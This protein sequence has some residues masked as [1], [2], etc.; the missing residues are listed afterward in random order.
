MT[1]T[2]AISKRILMEMM[3]DKRTLALMFLA[4]VLILTLLNYVFT[5]NSTPTVEIG[6]VRVEQVVTDSLKNT[7]HVNT[8]SYDSESKAKSALKDKD[9]DAV[10]TQTGTN[11]YQLRYANI[12]ASKTSMVRQVVNSTF[13]QNKVKA[14][15]Q[16]NVVLATQAGQQPAAT[17]SVSLSEKYNYGS[18]NTTFFDTIMPIFMGFFVFMFVFLISGISLLKERTTGTLSRLLATPVRR[19]EIVYGYMLSYAL[20][21]ILQTAVIVSFTITLLH[22]EVL[23]SVG[24]LFL[25]NIL[26]AMVALALGLLVS[27]LAASEFQMIQ[28]IPIV[29]V[30]QMIFSGIIPFN[31]MA[32]WAQIIGDVLPMKYAADA[33]NAVVL[34][35]QGFSSIWGQIVALL[36]FL[37]VL[38][39]ANIFGLR[40]YRKV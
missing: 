25:I 34:Q 19:S 15:A 36:I 7:S 38:T 11:Q 40:R 20:I 23:G 26:L 28:F 29:V 17:S 24:L 35:G 10:L 27:T 2:L 3:R 37:V 18:K 4:P 39:A 22:V 31:S 12:D 1:R 21:A 30:P 8:K 33:M 13:A 32:S 9:V 5:L 6:T 16:Q 14:M